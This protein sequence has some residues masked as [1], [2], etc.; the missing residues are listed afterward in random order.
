MFKKILISAVVLV[1]LS[2]SLFFN[3]RQNLPRS[4][5]HTYTKSTD[6][7]QENVNG[8]YL[9]DNIN[10]NTF[11]KVYGEQIHQSAD[12]DLYNYYKI[13]DGLEIATNA[14]GVILRF[15]VENSAM[16]TSK[17][18]KIGDSIT[19]VKRAYGGNFYKRTEQGLDVIGYVDKRNHQSIEF[20]HDKGKVLFY[21]LDDN[22]IQ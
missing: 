20:W 19:K 3:L 12:N 2:A 13:Q 7:H 16:P 14:K 8:F 11:I 21:R 1:I 10:I 18:I 15:I 4:F 17:G 22:N 9:F 5:H 6:L